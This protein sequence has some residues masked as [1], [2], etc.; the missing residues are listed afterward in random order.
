MAILGRINKLEEKA[1]SI[2]DVM[3]RK[4]AEFKQREEYFHFLNQ[5]MKRCH[6]EHGW[7]KLPMKERLRIYNKKGPTGT[8]KMTKCG[9]PV[10]IPSKK[11]ED[12]LFRDA[13]RLLIDAL[14]QELKRRRKLRSGKIIKNQ[15]R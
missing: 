1:K 14:H 4:K 12:I 6:S 5:V 8:V 7:C 10:H 2:T 11:K 3:L 15:L 13:N 9:L